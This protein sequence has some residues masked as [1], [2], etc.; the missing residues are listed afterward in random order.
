MNV[1]RKTI[2]ILIITLFVLIT[3]AVVFLS[4]RYTPPILMYHNLDNEFMRSKLSVSPESFDKQ[5]R[6]ISRHYNPV[7]LKE[8]AAMVKNKE[9]I[10]KGTIAITFDDGYENNYTSG[11]PVL[12]KYRIKATIFLIVDKINTPG[13]LTEE[14]IKEMHQSG[15][16]DF[17]AHTLTHPYLTEIP[18]LRLKQEIYDSKKKLE[19]MFGWEYEVFAYPG[20]RFNQNAKEMVEE[21]GYFAAVATSPG[22][23]FPNDDIYALKRVRISRSSDNSWVF[24]LYS[25]GEYI[26]IKEMRDE[27]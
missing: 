22:E 13:Y 18:K 16:V 4:E 3:G 26:W 20:G 12:K 24:W 11:Y 14:Q 6:F 9:K 2:F 8:L 15:L 5:M 17:G 23:K 25:S 1:I 27:E 10:P 21:A 19:E 7:S